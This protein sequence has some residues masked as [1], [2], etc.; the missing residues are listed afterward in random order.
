[1]R[2][3]AAVAAQALFGE[4]PLRETAVRGTSRS[5]TIAQALA[6]LLEPADLFHT[7]DGRGYATVHIDSHCETWPVR[8]KRFKAWL[9]RAYYA[10]ARKPAPTQAM[11]ETL[12]LAEAR[13]LDGPEWPVHVR[14]AASG[15]KIYIDLGDDRWRVVEVDATGWRMLE[16]SPVKFHRAA[17]MLPLPAPVPGET[18]EALRGFVNVGDENTWRLLVH[19]LVMGFRPIGPYP[20]LGV[21]GEQGSAKSTTT[22]VL[23]ELLDPNAA[24]LRSE[25]REPRDLMIAAEHGGVVA[26]D[27]LSHLPTWL[28]DALCRL[29]TGG[30]FSTRELYSDSEEVIF[31]AMRP[32][33]LN[34]IEEVITRGDLMQRTM[35]IELP[36][37]G[38]EHRRREGEF[39]RAFEAARPG[40][41]G[42]LLDAVA[43]AIREAP[44]VR[45]PMLPRMA[46]FAEWSVAAERGL[47]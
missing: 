18:L 23:R 12:A 25:P 6:A 30:G 44:N 21:F 26:L 46:D 37:I 11:S 36:V 4:Q 39:W 43:A 7:A 27:N 19:W 41:L 15:E 28:S 2:G 14:A 38:P 5:I 9:G 35:L 24:P 22:R 16:G 8:S 40:I 34:G 31:S 17:G 33:I 1:V 45:L 10:I 29:S 47:G 32:V 13:A 42:A 20:V 3:D